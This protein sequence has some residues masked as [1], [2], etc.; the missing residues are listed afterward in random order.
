MLT[1]LTFAS[2]FYIV[3]LARL[4]TASAASSHA[5][6]LLAQVQI[7]VASPGHLR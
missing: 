6:M 2:A 7:H 3:A 1:R 4:E 5:L